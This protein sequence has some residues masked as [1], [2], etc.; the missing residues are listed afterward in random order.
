MSSSY[1]QLPVTASEAHFSNALFGTV[2]RSR[3]S[4]PVRNSTTMN[5]GDIVPIYCKE[6][7]PREYKKIDFDAV[8][9]QT[10]LLTPTMGNMFLDL[11][12]FFV[13]NRVVNHSTAS[14]FGE[15]VNG[16]W[17]AP[18]VSYVPLVNTAS[19]SVQI[20]IG[21]VA[22]YY[23][24]PT[25]ALLP[26]NVLVKCNDLKFRG[27]IEIYNQYFRDQN[28]Q[29]PVPYSKLNIYQ[30]FLDSGTVSSSSNQLTPTTVADNSPGAGSIKQAVFGD[31][32]NTGTIPANSFNFTSSW[33]AT[34]APLKA[35]K[36]H[37]YFTSVLP[38]SQKSQQLFVPIA[39]NSAPVYSGPVTNPRPSNIASLR[40]ATVNGNPSFGS[41]SSYP[42]YTYSGS[43]GPESIATNF[44]NDSPVS[45]E[46]G[47]QL[48]PANLYADLA[49]AG[50]SVSDLRTTFAVQQLYEQLA[51]GGSRYREYVRSVFGLEVDDPYKDIPTYLGHVRRELQLYQTAQTS[52]SEEGSAQGNLAAFGYTSTGGNLFEFE[53]LEHGYLHI[54][55]V[56]RHTNVYP[57]LLD[58]DNFRLS[59]LDYYHP[60]LANISEQPVYTCQINPFYNSNPE[61]VFGY[62][63]AWAEYRYE[64]DMVTGY[65]RPGIDGSLSIWN[66]ADPA[67]KNLT[68]ATGEW[69]K[70]NSQEV[71][72]RTLAV[73]SSVAPQFK[74][75]FRFYVTKELPMPTYSVPG[76]DIV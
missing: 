21:S 41:S 40:W 32:Q 69:L 33:K 2:E 62:Q 58:R 16:S 76:L 42:L 18:S 53:A 23:G 38:S 28:Y 46:I 49:S 75:Q 56:I 31:L 57:H 73:Q 47:R 67:N 11:Y 22:D 13:P 35:N 55:A 51:R 72:D 17:V 27:Y 34:M 63:E 61:Q 12:A 26:K 5:A 29:P 45:G 1:N 59:L 8:I 24:F 60:T 65:M 74:A 6:M 43:S 10:T 7:L 37:D 4:F 66:Y 68:I 15:N 70:S 54:L 36:L 14:V 48:W 30:G 52:A 50:L 20:P 9:R 39:G 71:L 44:N 25:Q 19:G 3:M 64:N